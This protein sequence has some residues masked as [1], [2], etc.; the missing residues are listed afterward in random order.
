[1]REHFGEQLKDLNLAAWREG[2]N[3][4]YEYYKTNTKELPDTIQEM[5]PLYAAVLHGCQ[6]GKYQEAFFEVYWKRIQRG[7]ESFNT[8]KLGALGAE[9]A[10]L[11]GFFN[12]PWRKP[13]DGLRED[14][15]GFILNE[16]G[17][18][19]RALGRLAEAAQP[20]QAGLD[21]AIAITNWVN[22]ASAAS[23]I[24]ELY[25][26]LG[27]VNQ[28]LAY[29]EQSVQLADRSDGEFWKM[30]TRT[31]FADAL[32]QAGRLAEAETMFCEAE[33]VQEKSQM[34]SSEI[35]VSVWGFRYCNLFLDQGKYTEVQRRMKQSLALVQRL[36]EDLLSIALNTL[37]LGRAKLLQAMSLRGS[38]VTEAISHAETGIIS[39]PAE[40]RNEIL[41][42]LNRAVDGL[43]Q[44]G[45]Q[46]YLPYGL[47]A[48]VEFYRVT[49][50]LDKAQKDL[51]EAFSI[52]TRGGMGLYLADCNLGFARLKVERLQVEGS[53]EGDY[54]GE[55]REH[56]KTAKEMIAKMGY[57]RRDKEVEELEEEL[58]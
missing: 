49:G 19:L 15:K 8:K 4:L 53:G 10:V 40:A 31:T 44:A 2:N 25:L 5:A 6:A 41:L 50:V 38:E 29:A 1:M 58:K 7:N 3:R 46:S 34:W 18:D 43:R 23:T 42:H 27:D 22:A 24:S 33:A 36:N 26:T 39:S 37:S 16:A 52:A 9:L 51:D 55:A 13:V 56:L 45:D 54:L 57:H 47:L 32:H 28:A 30:T 48:R 12:P 35:L 11:S 14:Y 21:V 20:M 17:Y